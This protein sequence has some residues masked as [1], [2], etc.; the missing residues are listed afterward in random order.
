VTY[1]DYLTLEHILFS[2]VNRMSINYIDIPA[3][4][5]LYRSAPN[6]CEYRHERIGTTA[7]PNSNTGKTGVYFG[8]NPMIS[9]AMT[10]EYK[11]DMELGQF[12]VTE[13]LRALF[14][15]YSYRNLEPN[16]Y[17]NQ[18]KL[19]IGR[20]PKPEHNV[21]HYN[22]TMMSI[23]DI[24]GY[25][26]LAIEGFLPSGQPEYTGFRGEI[27][28]HGEADLRKIRLEKTWKISWGALRDFIKYTFDKFLFVNQINILRENAAK[29][30]DTA[31]LQALTRYAEE[32]VPTMYRD[33]NSYIPDTTEDYEQRGVITPMDCVTN[34]RGGG[35]RQTRRRHRTTAA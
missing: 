21:S 1:T 26:D 10:L 22:T 19:I 6:I 5:I 23:L 9:L 15:K 35:R 16:Y 30:P 11:K 7:R 27:F 29:Y 33:E 17:Y 13:P 14:G 31:G 4:T 20:A 28:V 24:D 12:T 25:E 34:A 18:G 32:L 3:G 2:V 8:F